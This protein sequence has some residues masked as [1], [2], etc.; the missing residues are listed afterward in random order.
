[1]IEQTMKKEINGTTYLQIA[2][3]PRE[4]TDPRRDQRHGFSRCHFFAHAVTSRRFHRVAPTF[5][6]DRCEEPR[7]ADDHG[8]AL[9]SAAEELGDLG[10]AESSCRRHGWIAGSRAAPSGRS[11]LRLPTPFTAF[12]VLAPADPGACDRSPAADGDSQEARS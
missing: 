2:V 4:D 3:R 5:V 8:R 12:Q 10:Q 9:V 7:P 11:T 1:V 6:A